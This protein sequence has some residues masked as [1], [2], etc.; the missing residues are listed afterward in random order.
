MVF[1]CGSPSWLIKD[2]IIQGWVWAPE[3]HESQGY[4]S[5]LKSS[6][7]STQEKLT[8][9][10]KTREKPMSQLGHCRGVRALGL[11]LNSNG[12]AKWVSEPYCLWNWDKNIQH[13]WVWGRFI[14][15]THKKK[16]LYTPTVC[17]HT[18]YGSIELSGPPLAIPSLKFQFS[19]T[20]SG[21]G[22]AQAARA[23]CGELQLGPLSWP[24]KLLPG[25]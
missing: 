13:R 15:I 1:C 23:D 4:S 24:S 8:A 20:V 3:N 16:T 18:N 19:S 11:S 17:T 25:G 12:A 14:E 5:R 7:L 10:L 2:G 22:G 6:R 21:W 9:G